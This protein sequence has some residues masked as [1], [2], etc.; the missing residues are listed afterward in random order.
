M[1]SDAQ[2]LSALKII[3]DAHLSI[4]VDRLI[5]LTQN[6]ACL[7]CRRHILVDLLVDLQ[8][9][10]YTVRKTGEDLSKPLSPSLVKERD[11]VLQ[12][13]GYCCEFLQDRDGRTGGLHFDGKDAVNI[14]KI[15]DDRPHGVTPWE[16][17]T[18]EERLNVVEFIA[19]PGHSWTLRARLIYE[20]LRR[21]WTGEE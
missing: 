10:G 12:I 13:L 4:D 11:P 20:H 5:A 17:L 7:M 1:A 6:C 18:P 8:A 16:E 21:K 15:Y 3:E 9:R 14:R 2:T 19:I